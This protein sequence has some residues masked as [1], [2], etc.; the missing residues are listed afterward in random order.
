MSDYTTVIFKGFSHPVSFNVASV[1]AE[2]SIFGH[3][4]T[5]HWY[6]AIIAF[7]FALAVL[8]GGRK[9]YV[10]K[11]SI[12][13]MID[14]LIYGTVAGIIGARLYYVFSQ[15]DYYGKNPGEI[16]RIWN[17]GLAIYGGLIGGVA[18]AVIVCKVRK[19]NFFNLLDL[20]AMSF[21]LA[22]GIGRWGNFTNQEAFGTNTNMPWGMTSEKVQSYLLVNQSELAARGMNI[23]PTGYVHPTFLYESIWCILGFIILFIICQ[24][25]RKFSGQLALC[26]GVWYGA[27]RAVVEGLRTDSL[28]IANTN[29]RVSQLLSAVLALVCLVLLIALTVKYT[30]HPKPIDGIDFFLEEELKKQKAPET[31][32]EQG[33]KEEMSSQTDSAEDENNQGE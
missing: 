8:F 32:A 6:G 25:A 5:I 28:Y 24:K 11:M 7:G 26:Y 12:D 27:E 10:W 3:E 14:V 18:A 15:W 33:N 23:N 1:L 30:K 9:A 20:I 21:L 29:I 2:F 31:E 22:Q 13:K 17:G 16:I 19:M 4:I